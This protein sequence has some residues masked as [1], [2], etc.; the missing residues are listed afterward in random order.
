MIPPRFECY[1]VS[2][3]FIWSFEGRYPVYPRSDAA[4]LDSINA[5]E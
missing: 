3:T 2:R 4:L 1:G 5:E